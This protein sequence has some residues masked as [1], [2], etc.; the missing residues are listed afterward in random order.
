MSKFQWEHDLAERPF[1]EQLEA[2]GWQWV[3]GVAERLMTGLLTGRIR[4]P[5]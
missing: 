5:A 4:V 3:E 1:C 2:M